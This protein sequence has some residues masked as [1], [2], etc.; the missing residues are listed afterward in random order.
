MIFLLPCPLLTWVNLGK[1]FFKPLPFIPVVWC[2][3][4]C[5][6]QCVSIPFLIFSVLAWLI[7]TFHLSIIMKIFQMV[8]SS[9]SD[10][11]W[12]LQ[13]SIYY[14]WTLQCVQSSGTSISVLLDHILHSAPL[15]NYFASNLLMQLYSK[16]WS[17]RNP[18]CHNQLLFFHLC[19]C[20]YFT[21]I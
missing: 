14:L 5:W 19:I 2:F 16:I 4:H 12:Q 20:P 3:L 8:V 7:W 21:C 6:P 15:P 18:L 9:L 11:I 10:T 17:F 13:G 1:I